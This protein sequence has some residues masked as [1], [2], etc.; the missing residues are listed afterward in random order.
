MSQLEYMDLEVVTIDHEGMTGAFI[1]MREDDTHFAIPF[2]FNGERRELSYHPDAA[3]CIED[4]R[5]QFFLDV[6]QTW[7]D[8]IRDCIVRREQAVARER[9]RNVKAAT[10]DWSL[11]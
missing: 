3:D 9:L 11:N 4:F 6:Q 7:L 1:M 8:Y 2:S 10:L 5:T